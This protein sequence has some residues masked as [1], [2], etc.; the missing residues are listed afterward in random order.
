MHLLIV[1]DDKVARTVIK[2]H[3]MAMQPD[4]KITEAENGAQALFLFFKKKPDFVFLDL[5]MPLVDGRAFLD[6]IKECY[7]CGLQIKKPRL[8]LVTMLNNTQID[9]I[10]PLRDNPFIEAVIK[11]PVT[12]NKLKALE[13]LFPANNEN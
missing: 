4:C 8:V 5:M 7:R 11:K 10:C 13:E 9:Q 6:V 1:D 2:N 12:K 3:L